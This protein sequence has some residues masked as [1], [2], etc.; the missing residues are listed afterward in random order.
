MRLRPWITSLCIA[1]AAAS[2]S[3]V[4]LTGN[5]P[6][7]RTIGQIFDD[8]KIKNV[9]IQRINAADERLAAS[10]IN[11]ASYF[12]VVLLTGQVEK[13]ALRVLAERAIADVEK[14]RKIYNEIQISGPNSLVARANDNWLAAKVRSRFAVS[15]KV[16]ATRIKVVAERDVIYLM[17]VVPR[18]HADAAVE[19]ARAVFGVSK[20]VKIFDYP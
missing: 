8:Q 18:D 2:T 19:I 1:I 7:K 16:D 13:E 9:A 10:H 4:S 14:I 17:G 20:V 15:G 11:V 5:D 12:G 6:T 3:C